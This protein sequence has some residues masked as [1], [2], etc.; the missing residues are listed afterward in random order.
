MDR[1]LAVNCKY[2]VMEQRNYFKNYHT[3]SKESNY[4]VSVDYD[5]CSNLV[6]RLPCNIRNWK[7]KLIKKNK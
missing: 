1:I 3:N 6:R 7:S 4:F 2:Q 5:C